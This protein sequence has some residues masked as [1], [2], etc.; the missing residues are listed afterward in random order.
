M[1]RVEERQAAAALR[2]VYF[3]TRA[4]V[5]VSGHF[6]AAAQALAAHRVKPLGGCREAVFSARD[7][8]LD[9]A[10]PDDASLNDATWPAPVGNP[11]GLP[12]RTDE[13]SFLL[14]PCAHGIGVF[15]A[16]DIRAGTY[17]RLDKDPDAEISR[18]VRR[19]EVP[20]EF[21]KYCI[22]LD[23]EWVIRPNDFG[24]LEV[25]WFLNHCASPNAGHRDFR[26]HAL[27]DIRAGEEIT[28]D[29][30]SLEPDRDFGPD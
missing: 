2:R 29:Y 16:H 1:G 8:R 19:D 20:G 7:T 3:P 9:E 14:R 30:R 24:H 6:L 25:V 22:E 13:F 5:P 17:L 28:I 23:A 27:R 4:P 12:D 18:K 15:A 21:I 11:R 26:Y 10:R